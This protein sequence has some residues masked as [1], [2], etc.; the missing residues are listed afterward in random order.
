M[1]TTK[2][3]ANAIVMGALAASSMA[4]AQSGD[5]PK[6][7]PIN[8]VVPFPPGGLT[9]VLAR[10]MAKDMQEALKQNV[11]VENRAGASGQIGTQY[12]ANAAPD[13]Y[14]LLVSA[15]HHAI[16]PA[17]KSNLPYDP[18]K[19]FTDIALLGTTPNLLLVNPDKIKVK[20]FKEF[21]EYSKK[22]K[23]GVPFASTSIGGSTHL[24]GELLKMMTGLPLVHVPY[25]GTTPAL[26]DLLGGQVPAAF[27]DISAV[28]PHLKEGKLQALGLTSKERLTVVPDVP[29]LDEEGVKG[30]EATTWIG[31]YGPANLPKEIAETLNKIAVESMHNQANNEWITSNGII[32]S[33]LNSEDFHTFVHSELEKWKKVVTEAGVKVE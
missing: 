22:Q 14:T 18:Y 2:F 19:S 13:G 6:K 24:S 1:K 16:N 5:W 26:A 30:Y 12:V 25:R 8:I 27:L 9:D 31:F 23:D 17:L 15:T 20:D 10:R 11:V 28:L 32:A 3:I 21:V 7:Q 4:Y 33:R 29:T